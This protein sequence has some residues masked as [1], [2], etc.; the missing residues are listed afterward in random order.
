MKKKRGKLERIQLKCAR[1]RN[2]Q[3]Q[4]AHGGTWSA[5]GGEVG[6]RGGKRADCSTG[7]QV[8]SQPA[9]KQLNPP[10]TGRRKL[11]EQKR[12]KK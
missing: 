4:G 5:W 1:L 11:A 9:G 2:V 8:P 6:H 7:G 12:N 3:G 10:T